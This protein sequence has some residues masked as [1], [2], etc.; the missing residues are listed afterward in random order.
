MRDIT[1]A[2]AHLTGEHPARACRVCGCT[3]HDACLHP[4]TAAGPARPCSWVAVDLCS[5]C[6]NTIAGLMLVLQKADH[7]VEAFL[8]I[9]VTHESARLGL[10]APELRRV[11]N[12][13]RPRRA[14]LH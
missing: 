12:A 13:N 5:V 6:A 8:K 11:A 2:F 14:G 10:T 1:G 3:E 4:P 7:E 9:V